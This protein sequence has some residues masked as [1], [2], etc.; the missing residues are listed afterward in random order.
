[1]FTKDLPIDSDYP[2]SCVYWI[3][4]EDKH[5]NPHLE[6]Y[7][8]VSVHGYKIRYTQHKSDALHRSSNPVHNAIR[9]Y[10]DKMKCVE[11]LKANSEFCLLFEEMMRPEEKIGYNLAKGGGYAPMLGQRHSED[12]KNK[13]SLAH[14][15][16][17]SHMWGKKHSEEAKIKI[18][19][20]NTGRVVSEEN[21]RLASER[22][23]AEKNPFFGKT[24]SEEVVQKLS[25]IN[26]GKT[27]SNETKAKMGALVKGRRHS[28][29][30]L[31][32]MSKDGLLKS[33]RPAKKQG[34]KK[35]PEQK[36]LVSEQNKK[37]FE[38]PW[39]VPKCN[40]SVWSRAKEIFNYMEQYPSHKTTA[41]GKAFGLT[42]SAV[43]TMFYKIQGGWSPHE[44]TSYHDWLAQF[45]I[46]KEAENV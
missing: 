13:M 35:T 4:H 1:M 11:L 12:S 34:T 32:K 9:K 23:S 27:L 24:H 20:A 41:V 40:H 7:I 14:S 46:M 39:N 22:M 26:T 19:I 44:D 21:K 5:T 30:A 45:K 36:K 6:G 3:Y 43:L 16:E 17:K 28:D 10:G 25:K 31:R 38:L 18:S 29:E 2:E 42:S 37:R 33:E 8:G 15:G